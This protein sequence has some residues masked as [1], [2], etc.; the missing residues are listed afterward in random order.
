MAV[1]VATRENLPVIERLLRMGRFV[2]SGLAMEDLPGVVERGMTLLAGERNYPWGLL[3]VDPEV[4]PSTLPAD[5]PDRA[6]V[7]AVALRQGPWIAS[8]GVEFGAGLQQVAEQRL[9]LEDE[10]RLRLEDEQRLRLEDE[11]RGRALAVSAYAAEG[12]LRTFLQQAGFAEVDAVVFFLLPALENRPLAPLYSPE[13]LTLRAA[14]AVDLPAIAALDASTFIPLWHFGHA[15][16][17]ELLL[18]GEVRVAIAE[19]GSPL[20]ALLEQ[21][22]DSSGDGQSVQPL[23]PPPQV[24]GAYLVGYSAL[25]AGRSHEAHLARLAVH[26]AAQGHGVGRVLLEEAIHTARQQGA[27]ALALNTQRSNARSQRLYRAAGFMETG[28]VLSVYLRQLP[29]HR[30]ASAT[31]PL[32]GHSGR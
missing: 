22:R 10:Q 11:P 5:A 21:G 20:A 32:A 31:D 23:P 15:E 30:Q 2:S 16:I 12:W 29:E 24:N 13:G 17:M 6:E 27:S 14:E 9:R 1:E 18:R 3:V 25:L 4:R 8:A 19:A 7:R 28:L 26:P